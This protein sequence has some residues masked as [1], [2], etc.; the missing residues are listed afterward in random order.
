MCPVCHVRLGYISH[1]SL[2]DDKF[3]EFSFNSRIISS[4][5]KPYF[6]F[7]L[8]LPCRFVIVSTVFQSVYHHLENTLLTHWPPPGHLSSSANKT[9]WPWEDTS[10]SQLQVEAKEGIH[11]FYLKHVQAV[12]SGGATQTTNLETSQSPSNTISL[13][14]PILGLCDDDIHFTFKKFCTNIS[15]KSSLDNKKC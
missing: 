3:S 12:L 14:F 8:P 5:R 15:I 13:L 4:S 9:V 2:V 11:G 7:N 10:C 1:L 6:L